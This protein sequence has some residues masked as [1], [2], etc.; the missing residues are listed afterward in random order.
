M[1]SGTHI[2]A[3]GDAAGIPER[4]PR[5]WSCAGDLGRIGFEEIKLVQRVVTSDSAKEGQEHKK[6]SAK[7]EDYGGKA[8]DRS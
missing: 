2:V 1:H 5:S 7:D 6:E 4:P 3:I 8:E